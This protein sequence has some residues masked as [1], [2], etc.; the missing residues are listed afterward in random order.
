M[1]KLFPYDHDSSKEREKR[2]S[3]LEIIH[4]SRHIEK[5]HLSPN[6]IKN[7]NGLIKLLKA[8]LFNF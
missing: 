3:P 2:S 8:F 4:P 7:F 6:S 5:K 1:V